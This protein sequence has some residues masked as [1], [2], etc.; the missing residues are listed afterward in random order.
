MK[1]RFFCMI[2]ALCL[3]C[4]CTRKEAAQPQAQE[5]APAVPTGFSD[6]AE[7]SWYHDAVITCC[8]K[9]LM[10]G[11]GEDCFAPDAPVTRAML[12]T[13]LWRGVGS[14]EAGPADFSD[15]AEGKWYT[16]AVG[17]ASGK[18]IVNGVGDN[19]FAP[20]SPVTREQTA[21]ILQRWSRLGETGIHGLSYDTDSALL[22]DYADRGSISPWAEDAVLWAVANG[23]IGRD[24]PDSENL[25]PGD[26]TTRAELCVILARLTEK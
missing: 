10:Q 9:G 7:D 19:I 5:E 2:L 24:E 11:I 14:P 15:V 26:A 12:V 20:E 25:R 18:N 22:G 6:V 3:L 17:W 23:L 21:A 13:V 8:E 16:N 1:Y 4:G